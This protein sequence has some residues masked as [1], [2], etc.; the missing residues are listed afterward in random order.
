[1]SRTAKSHYELLELSASANA[2]TVERMF[3]YLSTKH[4][5]DRGGDKEKFSNLVKAFEVLR[6]PVSRDA[7][8]AQ[9]QK[10]KQER[11]GLVEHARQAG[12]DVEVRK[13]LLH[14]FYARRRQSVGSPGIGAMSIE[15]EMDLPEEMLSFHLWFFR[16]KGWIRREE[17][18]GMSITAEGVE[19]V[20]ASKFSVSKLARI[21]AEQ[22]S[23]QMPVM[24]V[25]QVQQA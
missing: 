21:E 5:P 13:Q 14:L 20:E 2:D 6:E 11:E 7:Y 8:D 23:I 10:E 3:R 17:D 1:M 16:E 4:H 15:K 22:Q 9:L 19:R 25:A 12:P 18:G 24:H